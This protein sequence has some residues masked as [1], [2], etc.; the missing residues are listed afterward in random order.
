MERSLRLP[1]IRRSE[2]DN[3]RMDLI[4]RGL[5]GIFGGK[6]LFM[7]ATC[8]SPVH[9]NGLPMVG[10]ADHD[11]A[12]LRRKDDDTYYTDYPDVFVSPH[13][14]LL[15][16]SVE[17]YGRWGSD[18]LKLV[19]QM[20]RYKASDVSACLQKSVIQSFSKRAWGILSISLQKNIADSILHEFGADLS[21]AFGDDQGPPIDLLSDMHR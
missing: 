17:T 14:K 20:A 3:R 7:D 8:I 15:S 4:T 16:L 21:E 6:P 13:A 11:G 12:C 2:N 9:G 18:S 19:R 5:S 1:H 10:A